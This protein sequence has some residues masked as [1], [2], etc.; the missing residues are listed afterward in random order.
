MCRWSTVCCVAFVEEEGEGRKERP[1]Q[2][3]E[4]TQDKRRQDKTRQDETSAY[5]VRTDIYGHLSVI[6]Y[7]PG[8]PWPEQLIIGPADVFRTYL[9]KLII[10]PAD[11]KRTFS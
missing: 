4:T 6:N 10:G 2:T 5:T 1:R 11:Q 7:W 9:G 3:H 8:G